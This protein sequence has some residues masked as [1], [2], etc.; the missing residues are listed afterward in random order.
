[1]RIKRAMTIPHLT[2]AGYGKK[3]SNPIPRRMKKTEIKSLKESRF[4]K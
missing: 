4:L 1:M 2:V 3:G